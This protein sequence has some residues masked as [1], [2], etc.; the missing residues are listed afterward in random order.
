MANLSIT[1]ICNKKCVYCFAYDTRSEYGTSYMDEETFDSALDY[2]ERS[3]IKQVRLLGGEPTLHPDFISFVQ[4][5][6]NKNLDIMVFTNGLMSDRVLDFLSEIPRGRLTVLL[7]TIHPNEKNHSGILRQ[8]E[9]M[10]R[11]GNTIIPGVNIYSRLFDLTYL[12]DYFPDFDLKKEIR[13][14][15]AH[16]VLSRNNRFLHPK[17]Y[18]EVGLKI[19]E[20][21]MEMDKIGVKIGFD[22]GFVPCMFPHDSF[23][24]L[25]EELKKAGNCCHPLIDMLSDGSF[26]PCYPLNNLIKIKLNNQIDAPVLI[27]RFSDRLKPYQDIGIYPHC[28]I[29]PLFKSRCNGGCMAF[30]IQRYIDQSR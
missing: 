13:L 3:H 17:E 7:N 12:S 4:K 9:V 25:N 8:R 26:I 15:I 1:N 11:I 14:G 20:F 19:V 21:K 10:S 5:S 24:F 16:S 2:L 23:E 29:C 28:S 22:C 30:K 6:L 18:S 27:K